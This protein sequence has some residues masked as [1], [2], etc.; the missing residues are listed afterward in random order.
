LLTAADVTNCPHR[1]ALDRGAE[2]ELFES[3]LTTEVRRRIRDGA[4]HRERVIAD[5]SSR[6]PDAVAT[7]DY[8]PTEAAA[9]AGVGLILRARLADTGVARRMMIVEALVR[10]S[11]SED[12]HPRYAPIIVK[13]NEAV[14]VAATRRMLRGTLDDLNPAAAEW[15]GGV[16][17]RRNEPMARNSALLCHATRVL[18]AFDLGDE[19]GYA[20]LIDR[21]SKLWWFA[22]R[23]PDD[24]WRLT[25][26][27][28]AHR[29]RLE[30]LL[31]HER[32]R[33][34]EGPFPTEPFWHRAC[35]TCPYT[36]RC[37]RALESTDDVSLV[38][39]TSR[40]QQIL[41]R[42]HGVATR[43]DLAR[44]DPQVAAVARDRVLVRE[45]EYGPEA[46]LGVVI[47]KLDEL[48]FR[49][50]SV[51]A[52]SPLRKLPGG[53]L[54][55]PTADVEIDVDMESYNEST[56]L[57]GALV[58]TR[59]HIPGIEEGYVHFV[60]W[61]A[62]TGEGEADLFSRFWRWFCSQRTTA[63]DAGATFRAYCFWAQAED[64]AMDRAILLAPTVSGTRVELDAF[65]R[66][67][68]RE[69]IDLH[70]VARD[71]IQTDGP[72]GLKALAK[73][74]GFAWRD[75]N[76]SGEASM[77]WYE[78]AVGP[79]GREASRRRLLEYNEDDCRATRAL[80]EWLNGP[81]N[82][83]PSRDDRP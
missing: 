66:A 18:D 54:Q 73:A 81:A 48:I 58:T 55:C 47:D 45:P 20:G 37:R 8:I 60:T 50:R 38:R 11:P 79:A 13:N 71:Q 52:R 1:V 56:Y 31:A 43:L 63:S 42:E 17:A 77:T 64:R 15:V 40:T 9:R 10:T 69:W 67:E 35:P 83:L 82:D 76:P 7:D 4:S 68:P 12:P 78:E 59:R 2:S 14:G 29:Q 36:D 70:E 33:L 27:D 80:R 30:I 34:G 22:L 16:G 26:Y 57:W 39:F 49:A 46:H 44:L 61:D 25:E 62:L 23:D 41:L 21:Q 28:E 5:L 74:A 6:H 75:E 53:S 19:H 3:D 72:L 24:A 51:V 32:W 65:R